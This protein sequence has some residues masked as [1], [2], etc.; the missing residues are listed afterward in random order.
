M[1]T[2]R[3]MIFGVYGE[4]V[5][6]T[7]LDSRNFHRKVTGTPGFVISASGETAGGR[8]RPAQLYRKGPAA[9]RH[10]PLLRS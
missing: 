7:T 6:G 4:A 5:W 10:P 3:Y 8:G 2:L 9:I 1:D